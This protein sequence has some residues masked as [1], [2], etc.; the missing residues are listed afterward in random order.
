MRAR[1]RILGNDP[2][3]VRFYLYNKTDAAE[4]T[5]G[6]DTYTAAT[7]DDDVY[8]LFVSAALNLTATKAFDLRVWHNLGVAKNLGVA[9]SLAGKKETYVT[10]E[11]I[12]YA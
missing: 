11:V 4:V 7:N 8:D 2:G 1:A 5:D 12:R 9:A 6:S 10:I 3:S